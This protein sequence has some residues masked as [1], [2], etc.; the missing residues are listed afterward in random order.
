ML[1]VPQAGHV[2]CPLPSSS[3][4]PPR[5]RAGAAFPA[6]SAAEAVAEAGGHL[7]SPRLQTG[8][9]SA[10]DEFVELYNPTPVALPLEGLELMYV[11]A[12]GSTVTR[13]ASWPVGA[14]H[15]AGGALLIVNNAGAYLPIADGT[16]TGGVAATGGAWALRIQGAATAIDAVGWGTATAWLETQPAPAPPPRARA[17]SGCPAARRIGS[18]HR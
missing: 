7:V 10:S 3:S 13:K 8:G 2:A 9:A 5:S 6:G 1:T 14:R 15:P 12:T 11:T 18:G 4:L 17:S 16:Y